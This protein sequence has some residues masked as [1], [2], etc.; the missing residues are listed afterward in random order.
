MIRPISYSER[1]ISDHQLDVQ[2]ALVDLELIRLDIQMTEYSTAEVWRFK[3]ELK[4]IKKGIKIARED[5]H[6]FPVGRK[7]LWQRLRIRL[8]QWSVQGRF[9]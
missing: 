1:F 4:V 7:W 9:E 2:E 5:L 3:D 8:Y 6:L